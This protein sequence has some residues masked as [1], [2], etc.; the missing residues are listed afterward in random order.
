MVYLLHAG[1]PAV[2]QMY[3]V[4]FKTL[5]ARKIREP[6]T[7]NVLCFEGGALVAA[8]AWPRLA[9][10]TTFFLHKT[11]LA[12][13]NTENIHTTIEININVI[14]VIFHGYRKAPVE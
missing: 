9:A 11:P 7:T 2:Q 14:F 8:A 13:K 6:T 12:F 5:L 10:A 1:T 3:E 4:K